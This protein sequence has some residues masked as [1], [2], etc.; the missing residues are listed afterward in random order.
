M[1]RFFFDIRVG[2]QTTLDSHWVDLPTLGAARADLMDA[3]GEI[4]RDTMPDGD[5]R[6]IIG[7]VRDEARQVVLRA[8]ISVKVESL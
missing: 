2:E 5:Q 4:T 7:E 3:L 6:E 8:T 1:P